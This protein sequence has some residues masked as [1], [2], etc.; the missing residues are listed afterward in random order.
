MATTALSIGDTIC[1]IVAP[2]FEKLGATKPDYRSVAQGVI[3]L[4]AGVAATSIG[5]LAHKANQMID[6][7]MQDGSKKILAKTALVIST[8]AAVIGLLTVTPLLE[9]RPLQRAK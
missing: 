8:G 1:N 6:T 7:K 9:Y 5:V 3:A 2:V 4:T